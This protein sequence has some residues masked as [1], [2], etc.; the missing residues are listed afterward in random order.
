[1]PRLSALRF[2][3]FV[4]IMWVCLDLWRQATHLICL[5]WGFF[6]CVYTYTYILYIYIYVYIHILYIYICIWF[7]FVYVYVHICNTRYI[8]P[9]KQLV[10]TVCTEVFVCTY[11]YICIYICIYISDLNICMYIYIHIYHI[12][13]RHIIWG[14]RLVSFVCAEVFVMYIYIYIDIHIR[15]LY[16]IYTYSYTYTGYIYHWAAL[17]VCLI[18]PFILYSRKQVKKIVVGLDQWRAMS[19]QRLCIYMRDTYTYVFA[20]A[21]C[22][23]FSQAG[24]QDSSR[25]RSVKSLL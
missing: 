18:G 7:V 25:F 2:P 5:H 13:T 9:G 20:R 15:Y 21:K 23:L 14:K 6:V 19:Y 22:P 24:T 17:G 16:N 12:Y 4:L 1:M 3:V 8:C 10:S 11:I